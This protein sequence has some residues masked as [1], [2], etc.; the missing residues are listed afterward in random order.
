MGGGGVQHLLD[1]VDVGGEGG[2]DNPLL[3]PLELPQKVWPTARSLM[4]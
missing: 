3:A 4:V 1:A 2:D